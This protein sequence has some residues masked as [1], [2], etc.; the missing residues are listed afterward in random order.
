M[1]RAALALEQ[2]RHRSTPGPLV[3]IVGGHL[4]QRLP[5]VTDLVDD[6]GEDLAEIG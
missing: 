3:R 5:S 2:V 1:F 4:G 6:L